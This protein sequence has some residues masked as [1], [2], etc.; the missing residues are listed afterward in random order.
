MIALK[1]SEPPVIEL[2]V[3]ELFIAGDIPAY[4][5][6]Y[7]VTPSDESQ[8]LPTAGKKM[9][10]DVTV[11][12]IPPEYVIPSGTK[13]I[14]ISANGTTTEDVSG[15]AAV[16]VEVNVPASAVDTGTKAITSN[17][18]HNVT[19]YES[20]EINVPNTYTASDEGKV[21]Q[22]GALVAQSSQTVTENG[23][24]DTTTKNEVV[25][26]V[27]DG[28]TFTLEW[29][30]TFTLC[31]ASENAPKKYRIK[32]PL[33][34]EAYLGFSAG[35][36]QDLTY[37]TGIEEVDFTDSSTPTGIGVMVNARM[38]WNN[39]Y[40]LKRVNFANVPLRGFYQAFEAVYGASKA[41][42]FEECIGLNFSLCGGANYRVGSTFKSC[43]ALTT[44]TLK[45]N[46]LG[47]LDMVDPSKNWL[48]FEASSLLTDASLISI[49][50]GLCATHTSKLVL[51]ATPKARCNSIMG[52]VSSVTDETGTY[53]FF[54]EDAGGS[55]SLTSFI[56][57]TKGWTLA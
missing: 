1:V 57:T 39:R 31:R 52:T 10:S 32:T 3:S 34:T 36:G 43:A 19:G 38:S 4:D 54:T 20:A 37:N 12:A 23:T 50:N 49:A 28:D 53:D 33:L 16:E 18:T 9:T 41:P 2:E 13:E 14:G 27:S 42:Y 24:Y 22:S 51:H 45:P 26:N 15:Y 47:Q 8:T 7:E 25:V 30:A 11:D 29:I 44:V 6:S 21:V 40:D 17:G 48:E 35:N 55:T 46:T 56:T 5:G